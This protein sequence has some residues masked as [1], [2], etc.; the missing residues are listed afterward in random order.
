VPSAFAA[1]ETGHWS[2]ARGDA[3]RLAGETVASGQQPQSADGG[4]PTHLHF[5]LGDEEAQGEIEVVG[6]GGQHEA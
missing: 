4:M 1:H 3:H 2:T 6:V 5:V